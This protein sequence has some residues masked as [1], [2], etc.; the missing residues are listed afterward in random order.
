MQLDV[1][2]EPTLRLRWMGRELHCSTKAAKM[3]RKI[4]HLL[5]EESRYRSTK[6]KSCNRKHIGSDV[7]LPENYMCCLT[8]VTF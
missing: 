6:V 7:S 3:F 4:V 2:I 1:D 8:V 5:G